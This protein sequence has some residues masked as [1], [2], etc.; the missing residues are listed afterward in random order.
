MIV[1]ALVPGGSILGALWSA[2]GEITRYVSSMFERAETDV[3]ESQYEH[4]TSSVFE[5]LY[6]VINKAGT[7]VIEF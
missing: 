1:R 7:S 3:E 6:F 5:K 2:K 4:S